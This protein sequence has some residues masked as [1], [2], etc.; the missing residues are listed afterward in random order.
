MSKKMNEVVKNEKRVGLYLPNVVGHVIVLF[1]LFKNEQAPCILN[2]TMGTQNIIDC[3]ETASL[4]TVI[5]SR[6]F[7][8]K[9]KPI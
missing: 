2:F 7:V 6:E 9:K 4:E 8:K 3:I 5:T 1:S